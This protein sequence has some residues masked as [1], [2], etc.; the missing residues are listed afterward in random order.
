VYDALG[1]ARQAYVLHSGFWVTWTNRGGP[2][3]SLGMPITNEYTQGPSETP[4]SEARQDFQLGYLYYK[5]GANPEITVH[6]YPVCAP[7]WTEQGWDPSVSYRIAQKYERYEAR[8]V[9][10]EATS[11]ARR[12]GTVWKQTF[13]YGFIAVPV[14]YTA[15]RVYAQEAE[16]DTSSSLYDPSSFIWTSVDLTSLTP[17]EYIDTDSSLASYINPFSGRWHVLLNGRNQRIYLL[18]LNSVGTV[19]GSLDVTAQTPLEYAAPATSP[20]GYVDVASGKHHLVF[21]GRNG[22]IQ[23]ADFHPNTGWTSRDLTSLASVPYG[24]LQS[25][26]YG[27]PDPLI[28][29]L[30]YVVFTAENRRIQEFT[31]EED[32]R[33]NILAVSASDLTSLAPVPYAAS[34]TS[35]F[36]FGNE[37]TGERFVIFTGENRRI[38]EFLFHPTSRSWSSL[39]L[40]S[41]APVEYADPTSEPIGYFDPF[42][43]NQRVLFTGIDQRIYQL[44]QDAITHQWSSLDLS[45][46]AAVAYA[47]LGSHPSCFTDPFQGLQHVV[48]LGENARVQ[49]LIFDPVSHVW[50]S[51]DLTSRIPVEYAQ[52]PSSPTSF[53]HPFSRNQFVLFSGNNARIQQMKFGQ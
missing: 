46:Q 1:G 44:E 51:E 36:A 20:S 48:F 3:S 10:G 33:G 9:Y 43:G 2:L 35:P 27:Y 22:R 53:L 15:G 23:E 18:T 6:T 12:D 5:Q 41:L 37:T 28:P 52:L 40:T 39:D 19:L 29:G 25:E 34:G 38:Q 45:A 7:G 50:T 24:D 47:A 42:T 31:I 13:Q 21:M 4:Y 30:R 11:V 8:N 26:P 16:P 17:V 49:H 32:A 14:E